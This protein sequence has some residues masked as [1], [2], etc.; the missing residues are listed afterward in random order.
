[1]DIQVGNLGK[2]CQPW[3]FW[4]GLFQHHV[5][6]AKHC[7]LNR[8]IHWLIHT[9]L[10]HFRL[11]EA[12]YQQMKLSHLM[13]KFF[14]LKTWNWTV[15]WGKN[16]TFLSDLHCWMWKCSLLVGLN[17][18]FHSV[19]SCIV[20]KRNINLKKIW[21]TWNFECRILAGKHIGPYYPQIG[22]RYR[23]KS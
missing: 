7:K 14:S 3:C 15:F 17:H 8:W 12:I 9:E 21:N 6:A 10:I 5:Q 1:M 4:K 16:F 19:I 22:C 13:W 2:I 20:I 18:A 11:I 23:S